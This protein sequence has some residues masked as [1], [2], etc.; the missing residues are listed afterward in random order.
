MTAATATRL[1]ALAT[2]TAAV[3]LLVVAAAAGTWVVVAAGALALAGVVSA[4][5]LVVTTCP[6]C[7]TVAVVTTAAQAVGAVLVSTVGVPGGSVRPV[8]G[9]TVALVA[10]A[11]TVCALLVV[12]RLRREAETTSPNSYAL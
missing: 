11:V 6:Y 2:A 3:L 5:R 1:A 7:S 8:D 9:V 10:L 4:V 12:A